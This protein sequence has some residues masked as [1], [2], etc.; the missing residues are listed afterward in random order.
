MTG[1]VPLNR[2]LSASWR[3]VKSFTL[4]PHY[5]HVISPF[6]YGVGSW[7]GPESFW[8]HGRWSVLVVHDFF[9]RS[10]QSLI[11]VSTVNCNCDTCNTLCK[12]FTTLRLETASHSQPAQFKNKLARQSICVIWPTTYF[13]LNS[14]PQSS[15]F[16]SQ[17]YFLFDSSFSSYSVLFKIGMSVQLGL[18]FIIL[19]PFSFVLLFS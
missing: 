7:V 13:R 8:Q 9:H 17:K 5:R 16:R 2:Y 12:I 14:I 15:P 1:V 19:Q 10:T 6:T 11:S 18:V 4:R 3:W